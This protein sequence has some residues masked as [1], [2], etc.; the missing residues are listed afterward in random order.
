MASILRSSG[1]FWVESFPT[2]RLG[3]AGVADSTERVL[4]AVAAFDTAVRAPL[5][6]VGGAAQM[7]HTGRQR[8]TDIDMVGSVDSRDKAALA[9]LGF[10]RDGRHWVCGTG[11]EEIAIEVPAE[12]LFGEDPPK[13]IEVRG[14]VVR[15]ISVNDLMVDRL[16]QAT[17]GTPV[18]WDEAVALAIAAQD[19][20]DWSL[21]ESRCRAAQADDFF[22]RNLPTVLDRLIEHLA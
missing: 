14:V 17:D 9:R 4:L 3:A 15:V 10:V 8:M 18:T 6:L 22:L 13:Q 5:V 2:D 20:I 7:I 1:G 19:R 21:V 11:D 16:V 12:T